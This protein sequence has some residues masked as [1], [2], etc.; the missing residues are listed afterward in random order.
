MMEN[1]NRKRIAYS[2]AASAAVVATECSNAEAEIVYSGLANIS[3]MQGYAQPLRFDQDPVATSPADLTLSNRVNPYVGLTGNFQG[4]FSPSYGTGFVGFSVGQLNYAK[5]LDAGYEVNSTNTG[6]G[7]FTGSL[8]FGSNHPNAQFNSA[9]DKFIGFCFATI[10]NNPLFHNG[11]VRVNINN[12]AGTFV[13]RDWAFETVLGAP[14]LAGDT[15]ISAGDY[16]FDG[17]VDGRDFLEWQRGKT[18][19][20]LSQQDLQTW[21]DNY[22]LG[23]GGPLTANVPEPTTLGLLAAGSLGINLLRRR[24][25]RD[26][27]DRT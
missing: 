22:G 18:L 14:I 6:A 16:D 20:P 2:L 19:N 17:D 4:V 10:D 3:I 23:T 26:H 12:S 5:A 7:F 25:R 9:I 1:V 11:W 15:G 21:K 27:V 8:A 13:I 24:G